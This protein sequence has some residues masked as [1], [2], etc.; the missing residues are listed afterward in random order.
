MDFGGVC[1]VSGVAM[2]VFFL[3]LR[4]WSG[5][6]AGANGCICAYVS[7]LAW[8]GLISWVYKCCM[9]AVGSLM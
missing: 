8:A 7:R 3:V 9:S 4:R 1:F 5:K 2:W 6:L